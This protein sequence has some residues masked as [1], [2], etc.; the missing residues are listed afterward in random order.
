MG[1]KCKYVRSCL[2]CIPALHVCVCVCVCVCSGVTSVGIARAF[3]CAKRMKNFSYSAEVARV[4]TGVLGRVLDTMSPTFPVT[5]CVGELLHACRVMQNLDPDHDGR[6]NVQAVYLTHVSPSGT[7][8]IPVHLQ[9]LNI[10]SAYIDGLRVRCVVSLFVS[11]A[12]WCDHF[13]HALIVC[14]AGGVH[15]HLQDPCLF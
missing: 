1:S 8:D 11:Y 7:D 3:K 10:L 9:T 4:K 12:S 5:K 13:T 6:S 14:V 15:R 2:V